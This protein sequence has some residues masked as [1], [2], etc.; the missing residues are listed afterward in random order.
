MK[1]ELKV[2]IITEIKHLISVDCSKVDIN[3]NYLEYF[4]LEELVD[5]KDELVSK[6]KH[7]YKFAKQYVEE[8]SDILTY[9]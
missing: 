6:K 9:K 8:L 4:T 1:D 2:E 3:P 5:I 7:Q